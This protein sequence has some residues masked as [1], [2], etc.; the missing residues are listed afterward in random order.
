MI[1]VIIIIIISSSS[2]SIT[3]IIIAHYC[4]NQATKILV[5]CC[6]RWRT[7]GANS[8]PTGVV[9]CVSGMRCL[10]L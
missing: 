1:I 6:Q 3:V 9:T 10:R 4:I 2:S 7:R 8:V 5:H